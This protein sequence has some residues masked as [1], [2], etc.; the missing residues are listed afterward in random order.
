MSG[1]ETCNSLAYD[2]FDKEKADRPLPLREENNKCNTT[3]E[4]EK[5]ES[6]SE[7]KNKK[8]RISTYLSH[9]TATQKA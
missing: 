2:K 3:A 1:K 9:K 5:E 6:P 7:I 4:N 8:R